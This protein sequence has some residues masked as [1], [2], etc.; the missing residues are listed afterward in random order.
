MPAHTRNRRSFPF[1]RTAL[2]SPVRIL[3]YYM[4]KRTLNRLDH[5]E[6]RMLSDIGLTRDEMQCIRRTVS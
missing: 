6:D 1:G 5:L 4:L 2:F 3:R